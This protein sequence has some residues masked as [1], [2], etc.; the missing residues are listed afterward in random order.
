MENVHRRLRAV[1]CELCGKGF[2]DNKA[3]K[4]HKNAVHLGLRIKCEKCERDFSHPSGLHKHL[5]R[6]HEGVKIICPY[7]QKNVSDLKIHILNHHEQENKINLG[8]LRPTD[9]NFAP[10]INITAPKLNL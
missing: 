1:Q 3:M 7:C 8:S 2:E 9:L 4:Q 6:D 5:K 10:K